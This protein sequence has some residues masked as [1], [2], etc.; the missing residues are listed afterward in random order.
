MALSAATIERVKSTK[1]GRMAALSRVEEQVGW[2]SDVPYKLYWLNSGLCAA[3]DWESNGVETKEDFRELFN[4]RVT[5]ILTCLKE[6]ETY[7]AQ[8][9][10]ILDED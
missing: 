10:N 3:L 4:Q 5:P 6:L 8:L 9:R 1:F 2:P 7:L